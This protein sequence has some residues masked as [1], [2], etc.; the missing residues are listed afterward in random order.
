MHRLNQV[1]LPFPLNDPGGKNLWSILLDQAG[2]ISELNLMDSIQK[3]SGE[4]WGGDFLSPMAVDLQI[5]GGFGLSFTEITYKDKPKINDLLDQ[6]WIDGVE[7]IVPTFVSCSPSSLRTGL[8]VLRDIRLSTGAKRCQL[9]GAHLEGPFL[10]P[11]KKGAHDS[12]AL[13]IPSLSALNERIL[14]FEKESVF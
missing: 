14:G 2:C 6:L 8:N 7:A 11:E 13:V 3:Y 4:D 5:N 10:D 1:R 9:L 12:Q